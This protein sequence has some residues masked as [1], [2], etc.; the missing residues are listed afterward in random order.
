MYI[1]ATAAIEH[2]IDVLFTRAIAVGTKL[3]AR[4]ACVGQDAKLIDFY[5]GFHEH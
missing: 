4:C 5:I 2:S 3:W 1:A